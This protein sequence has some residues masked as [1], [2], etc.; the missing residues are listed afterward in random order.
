M[1]RLRLFGREGKGSPFDWLVVGL[2]NPGEK[3]RNT[4]HNVGEDVVRLLAERRGSTLKGGRDNALIAESRF[5]GP[6]GPGDERVALAFPITYMNESGRF[7]ESMGD[8]MV[9]RI[10]ILPGQ[11]TAYDS[12]GLEILAL[13]RQAEEALGEDFDI[14]E[15]HDK[16][17]ENG[18]IPLGY[19]RQHIEAW[20]ASKQD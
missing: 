11:L 9:D 20:I 12:G 10:A 18:T 2:G 14:R 13:R 17:L 16:V 7:P 3:Y 19:L 5:S 15:F 8:D 6:D 1:S 4:R